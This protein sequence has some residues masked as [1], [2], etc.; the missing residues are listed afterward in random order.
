MTAPAIKG[1]IVQGVVDDLNELRAQGRVPDPL[2]DSILIDEDVAILDS[3]LNPSS[4][5]P[6][7]SYD[8]FLRLLA[9]IEC[10]GK[11]SYF[12]ERGR[13]N[14]R[15]LMDAGLYQQ[16]DFMTRW[17]ESYRDLDGRAESFARSYKRN[18][19]LVVTLASSIYNVGDWVVETD[20]QWPARVQVT[21]RDASDYTEPMRLAIEGF[22]NECAHAARESLTELNCSERPREDLIHFH[23]T[24]DVTDLPEK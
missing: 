7:A 16:L 13:R 15:R 19:R 4:W 2:L 11:P 3:A 21:I 6:I 5:Y 9:E 14:A 8:G 22:V 10:D 24:M 18:L 1:S 17:K 20:S 23:M 12:V